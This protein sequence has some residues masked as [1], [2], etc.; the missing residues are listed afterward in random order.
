MIRFVKNIVAVIYQ[1]L[2]L[3]FLNNKECLSEK[4]LLFIETEKIGDIV[5]SSK[6]LEDNNL[7]SN[8][9][10]VYFLVKSEYKDLF[11]YYKGKVQIISFDHKRF[12]SSLY[13]NYRFAK[14]LKNLSVSEVYNISQARGQINEVLTQI[15]GAQAKYATNNSPIYLGK[16][17]LNYWNTKYTGLL[18][19]NIENEYDKINQLLLRFN[20][21]CSDFSGPRST[22]T[23]NQT[24]IFN[25]NPYVVINPYSSDRA[26]DWDISN[27]KNLIERL[28]LITNVCVLCS[29][30]QKESAL[31][32]FKSF[33]GIPQFLLSTADL[34]ETSSIISN[35]TLFI[36]NDSGLTHLALKLDVKTVAIIGGGTYGRYFPAPGKDAIA[37]YFYKELDCFKCNWIC[38]FDKPACL[39]G[40]TV[41]EIL[42]YISGMKIL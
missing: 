6:L 9:D 16:W 40:V 21:N 34:S 22:F 8:Y 32:E 42:D 17:F 18:F 41:N 12:L 29:T 33:L 31:N 24:G 35:A 36:G 2:L 25:K 37:K 1:K 20:S 27:Y 30:N 3:F 10:N 13:Y 28:L 14:Y 39:S 19:D 38:K 26:K 23:T 7:F 15:T 4:N 11:K 5:V